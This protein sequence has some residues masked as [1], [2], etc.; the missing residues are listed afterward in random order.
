MI[1][2]AA[3]ALGQTQATPVP[4]ETTVPARPPV[5]QLSSTQAPLL[6]D[7]RGR[8]V[9]TVKINGKGPFPMVVDTAA[10]TSLMNR[11]LAQ[12]LALKPLGGGIA[13]NGATGGGQSRLYPV[14]RLANPLIDARRVALVELA[15]DDV[16]DAR[17]IIG[18]EHF[19]K[20]KLVIDRSTQRIAAEPSGPAGPGFATVAGHANDLGFVEIPM[21]LDDVRITA[22]VDTGA[23]VTIANAAALRLLGWAENDPRLS[24]GGEIRGAS[25]RGQRV[26]IARI[27]KV[28]LGRIALSNVPI[29]VSD[30]HDPKPSVLLGNDILN[31][32]PAYGVDFPRAELQIKLPSKA[33]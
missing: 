13:V 17:G 32:F 19:A 16:T 26:R 22:L 31:L 24:A 5:A 21:T 23:A 6:H 14:D 12:E 28:A 20:R 29:M 2:I 8:P 25:A 11:T 27:G 30:D 4:A 7:R 18:M 33:K 3:L 15:N 10:Q 1:L 9:M